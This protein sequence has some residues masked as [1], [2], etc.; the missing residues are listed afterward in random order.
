LRAAL[1]APPK[2]KKK[3]PFASP[4]A[5]KNNPATMAKS[6]LAL[7]LAAVLLFAAAAAPAVAQD[8]SNNKNA[9]A[10]GEKKLDAEQ[11]RQALQSA[12][13]ESALL[14]RAPSCSSAATS[15]VAANTPGSPVGSSNA[16][17]ADQLKKCC[18]EL[19]ATVAADARVQPCLCDSQ[20]WNTAK[21][22]VA[23]AGLRGVDASSVEAFAKSCGLRFA[24]NGC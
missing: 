24:G 7:F 18:D 15:T 5:E 6:S 4:P 23:E 9:A 16:P 8:D 10:G 14:A 12:G 20:T 21:S 13:G 1:L 17:V 3:N 11:C 19:K 22:R 2:P